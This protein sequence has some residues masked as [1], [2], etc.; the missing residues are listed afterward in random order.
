MNSST[1][2]LTVILPVY[3]AEPYLKETIESILHQTF[4]DFE[5]LIADDG[6]ADKSKD[7][8]ALYEKDP[9][10][11]CLHNSQ[12]MGK[13]PTVNRVYPEARGKYI[14]IHD[15]DDVSVLTRFERAIALLEADE[16]LAMCGQSWQLMKTDGT[17][18]DYIRLKSS[19][20]AEI[21][22]GLLTTNSDGDPTMIIRS[23][24]IPSIGGLYR[25]YGKWC[26]EDH[27]L[28][29][30]II[31]KYKTTNIPDILY[32]YRTVPFS[33]SRRPNP[34]YRIYRDLVNF[35]ALQRQETGTDALLQNDLTSIAAKEAELMA[36][37]EKDKGL[38]YREY[39][40]AFLG[41]AMFPMA[42]YSAWLGIKADPWNHHNYRAFFYVLRQNIWQKLFPKKSK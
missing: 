7:I 21:R 20:Y 8:I 34:I 16:E 30:R 5:L 42:R 33:L 18:I 23:S 29:L 2:L 3:N 15:A 19:N 6:S 28:A 14:T 41:M 26:H 31:E 10:V 12:N 11:R 1:P 32:L 38:A 9:R 37:Y 13:I 27:D 36:I 40:A 4:T 22:A 25:L 35:L 39:A 24:I 17:L